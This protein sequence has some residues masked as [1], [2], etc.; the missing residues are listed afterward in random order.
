M[1]ARYETAS[2]RHA[3][4]RNLFPARFL[5]AV[6]SASSA[7]FMLSSTRPLLRHLL[8]VPPLRTAGEVGH[9]CRFD[10]GNPVR[11]PSRAV[12]VTIRE[13]RCAS[14]PLRGRRGAERAACH[15]VGAGRANRI[16]S[17]A[18]SRAVSRFLRPARMSPKGSTFCTLQRVHN[19][20]CLVD[21]ADRA[22]LSRAP[23]TSRV[24]ST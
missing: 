18:E 9:R 1:R 2:R 19:P 23:F 5:S 14:A 6:G 24:S 16:S 11:R 13:R 21:W 17:I 10:F 3:P 8:C 15:D 7:V 20:V 12:T 22:S 4:L